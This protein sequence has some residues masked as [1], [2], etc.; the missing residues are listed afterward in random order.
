M[1]R[2]RA[3]EFKTLLPLFFSMACL[4]ISANGHTESFTASVKLKLIDPSSLTSEQLLQFG[5]VKNIPDGQCTMNP[6]NGEL[7]GSSCIATRAHAPEVN[8]T[9]QKALD[10]TVNLSDASTD[11]IHFD[12]SLFNGSNQQNNFTLN[13]KQHAVTLGGTLSQ[14]ARY[15]KNVSELSYD[16]EVVYP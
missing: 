4:L 16:V 8:I 11:S 15:V 10:I 3:R 12:P 14:G 2:N 13:N 7:K 5:S 6:A 9:G 1:K